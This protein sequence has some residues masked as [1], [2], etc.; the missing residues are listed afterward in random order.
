MLIDKRDTPQ[1]FIMDYIVEANYRNADSV[2]II[3]SKG[4][5]YTAV[6]NLQF[7]LLELN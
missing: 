3:F 5:P 6:R 2:R 4:V 1:K 7:D